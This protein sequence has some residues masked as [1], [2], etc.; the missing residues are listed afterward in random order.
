MA[1]WLA[2]WLAQFS[3]VAGKEGWSYEVGF[4]LSELRLLPLLLLSCYSLLLL[5]VLSSATHN[6]CG[7]Q[8]QSTRQLLADALSWCCFSLLPPSYSSAA[9]GTTEQLL[10]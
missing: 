8:R 10:H 3:S 9:T 5:H 7:T 4:R 2:G 1:G 6:L